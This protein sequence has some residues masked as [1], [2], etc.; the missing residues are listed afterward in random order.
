MNFQ[1]VIDSLTKIISN[2]ADFIPLLV[3]GLIILLIGYLISVIVRTVIHFIFRRI[4][5]DELAERA[6]INRILKQLGVKVALSR[7]LS[8]VVFYFLLLSFATEAMRVMRL[9][10]IAELLVNILRFIPRAFGA[11]II[12]VVGSMLAR[13]LGDTI[14]AVAENVNITYSRGLGKIIEYAIVTFVAVLA[15]STLGL[16]TTIFTSSLVI[17]IA[18]AGLAFALTFGLGSRETARNVIAGYSVQQKFQTGQR[19]TFGETTGTV[20]AISGAFTTIETVDEQGDIED[21][22]LPNVLLLEKA[23][24]VRRNRPQ[25]EP[26][27]PSPET[28]I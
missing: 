12:I 24:R 5:L 9:E 22:V 14:T 25:P 7:I 6:G 28:A 27:G 13:F 18:S 17:I 20:R 16:D 15:V 11:G 1:P 19:V 8:L 3:N 2:I 23:S 21:L 26:P 4:R 10:S